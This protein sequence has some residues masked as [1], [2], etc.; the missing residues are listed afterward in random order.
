MKVCDAVLKARQA[1]VLLG[2]GLRGNE[3]MVRRIRKSGNP[4]GNGKEDKEKLFCC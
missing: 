3:E 2:K 1:M 4:F